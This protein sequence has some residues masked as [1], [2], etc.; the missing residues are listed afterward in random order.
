MKLVKNLIPHQFFITKGAGESKFTHHAGS[1]H[2]SLY[3]AGI[4]TCNIQTYSSILPAKA[5]EIKIPE[6]LVFGQELQCIMSVC[7]GRYGEKLAA[8]IAF[9]WLYDDD[10]NKIGGIVVERNGSFDEESLQEI[11]ND[12]LYEL[13]N[14]TFSE[15]KLDE[16][17]IQHVLKV[18]EPGDAYGTCLVSLCFVN[19]ISEKVEEEE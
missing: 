18:Y 15:Y 8:G 1:F 2:L 12:S 10:D 6:N 14:K 17:N 7:N 16:E 11:L 4:H 9:G 5:E 13:Y 19:Y 3:Q